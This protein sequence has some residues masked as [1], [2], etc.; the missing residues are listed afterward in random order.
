MHNVSR[1][2]MFRHGEDILCARDVT[3][4][5]RHEVLYANRS[6]ALLPS[7]S[8][9]RHKKEPSAASFVSYQ[10]PVLQHSLSFPAISS[11]HIQILE[12][13][14][15]AVLVMTWEMCLRAA[16]HMFRLCAILQYT[17]RYSSNVPS[18]ATRSLKASG[19]RA[20]LAS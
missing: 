13:Q 12:P 9:L 4:N 6:C 7:Q 8:P 10:P 5:Y 1:A 18:S 15:T 20:H 16:T 19:S 17:R 3:V 2:D 14:L 11:M